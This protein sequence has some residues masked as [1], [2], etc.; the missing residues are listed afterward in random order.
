MNKAERFEQPTAEMMQA[1]GAAARA[2]AGELAL[3][4]EA[5]KSEALVAAA[6]ALRTRCGQILAANAKD[7]EAARAAGRPA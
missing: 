3:A 1:M 2:A 6:Q 7:L 5:Q 4:P